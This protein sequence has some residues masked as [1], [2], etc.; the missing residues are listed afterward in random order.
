MRNNETGTIQRSWNWYGVDKTDSPH[1]SCGTDGSP[2]NISYHAPVLA[3]STVSINYTLPTSNWTFGH[4]YGPMIAYMA[5]CPSEGCE[6]VD[7]LSP[8]WFKIWQ[9]G[10]MSGNFVDGH[11]AMKDVMD[12]A[13]LDIPTPT[14]L[15]PGKYLLKHDMINLQTGPVQIFP[16]CI[17]LDITGSGSNLPAVKELVAFP[18]GYDKDSGKQYFGIATT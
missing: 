8:M 9:A 14:A 4:P 3:G 11:W 1:I 2:Y 5:A 13:N 12:G 18:G 10:L 7:L 17:E 15:K 16:N 6:G